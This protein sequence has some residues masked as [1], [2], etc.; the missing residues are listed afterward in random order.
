MYR[1][2]QGLGV[3]ADVGNKFDTDRLIQV[4][5]GLHR[6][7]C[8]KMAGESF[9]FDLQYYLGDNGAGEQVFVIAVLNLNHLSCTLIS[10]FN[11]YTHLRGEQTWRL[12]GKS[13]ENCNSLRT[14]LPFYNSLHTCLIFYKRLFTILPFC[15]SP[16]TTLPFYNSL[17]SARAGLTKSGIR[18]DHY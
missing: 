10:L 3:N 7:S 12:R 11:V 18:I 1:G 8:H 2:Q 5:W 4:E 14:S 13:V 16:C 17:L 15:N 6:I 9:G